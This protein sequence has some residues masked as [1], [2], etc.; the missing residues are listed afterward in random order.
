MVFVA[1]ETRTLSYSLEI[2]FRIIFFSFY[3]YFM[4][5]ITFVNQSLSFSIS[6]AIDQRRGQAIV[7]SEI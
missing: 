6:F 2:I 7:K 5:N 1:V 3:C 4:S